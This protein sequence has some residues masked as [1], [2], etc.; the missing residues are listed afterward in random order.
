[1][2]ENETDDYKNFKIEEEMYKFKANKLP[3]SRNV[4]YQLCDI[5]DEDVQQKLSQNIVINDFNTIN[6]RKGD[7]YYLFLDI[8]RPANALKE[9]AGMSITFKTNAAI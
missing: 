2:S 3:F 6:L 4:L 5:E 8:Y 9:M 7:F 1:M